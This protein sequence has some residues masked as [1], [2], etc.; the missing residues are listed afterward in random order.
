MR[1]FAIAGRLLRIS[2]GVAVDV[3]LVVVVLILILLIL[4]WLF[5]K[6]NA[7]RQTSTT[8]IRE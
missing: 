8:M 6:R 2:I 1:D 4:F 3:V 7:F 5:S